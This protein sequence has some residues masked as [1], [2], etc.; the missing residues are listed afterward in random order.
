MVT[1]NQKRTIQTSIKK[2]VNKRKRKKKKAIHI[3]HYTIFIKSQEKKRGREEKSPISTNP[4][5]FR[6]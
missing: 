1:T 4:K 2:K 6:K 5:L 3:Q